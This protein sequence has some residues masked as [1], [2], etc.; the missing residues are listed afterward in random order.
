M[1]HW[2]P[3]GDPNFFEIPMSQGVAWSTQE[4]SQVIAI[5]A[6]E[7]AFFKQ[8]CMAVGQ[9]HGSANSKAV[10]RVPLV[11]TGTSFFLRLQ[12]SAGKIQ[13]VQDLLH[14]IH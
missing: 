7:E 4:R 3:M 6:T 9:L 14:E 1:H 10:K 2:I 11:M 12:G 13:C 8:R 5:A